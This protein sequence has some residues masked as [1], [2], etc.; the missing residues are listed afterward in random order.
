MTNNKNV[1]G[2]I[3][4]NMVM[5]KTP[6]YGVLTKSDI[7]RKYGWLEDE[8]KEHIYAVYLNNKNKIIG[9]KLITLGTSNASLVDTQDITRVALLCNAQAVVLCHNHPSGDPTPSSDD[10][11][12]TQKIKKAL[13]YFD[14]KMLDHIVIGKNGSVSMKEI[15]EIF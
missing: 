7:L 15:G 2:S 10:V 8:I 9:D 11:N 12:V 6:S 3:R 13:N 1:L 14:I 5:E 4:I